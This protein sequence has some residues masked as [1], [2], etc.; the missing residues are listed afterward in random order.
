[1]R[2]VILDFEGFI[3]IANDGL[4]CESNNG[5]FI[6]KIIGIFWIRVKCGSVAKF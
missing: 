2:F 5:Y 4:L 1:M 3:F 6:V